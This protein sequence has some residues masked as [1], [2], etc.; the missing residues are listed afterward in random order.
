AVPRG[1]AVRHDAAHHPAHRLHRR[2]PARDAPPG[3]GLRPDRQPLGLLRRDP[4]PP[5]HRPP[6]PGLPRRD[7]LP[8]RAAAAQLGH[9]APRR[10]APPAPLHWAPPPALPRRDGLPP[11]GAAALLGLPAPGRLPRRAARGGPARRGRDGAG[12][13][14]LAPRA[15]LRGGGGPA[16]A[17]PGPG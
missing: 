7:R 14:G 15:R 6:P 1:G 10:R 16:G 9:P 8:P 2:A 13:G 3:L 4:P 17:L 12:G 5:L 11:R